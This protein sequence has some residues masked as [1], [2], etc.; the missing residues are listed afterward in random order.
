MPA[1][2]LS[3]RLLRH[4]LTCVFAMARFTY[5]SG[6]SAPRNVPQRTPIFSRTICTRSAA[7]WG[8]PVSK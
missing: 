5:G 2:R 3:R 7:S 6:L 1:T 4:L 8:L